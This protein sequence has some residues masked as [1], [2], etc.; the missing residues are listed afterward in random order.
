MK[1]ISTAA[2]A[3]L[4]G[5]LALT[6]G[7]AVGIH[8]P[9]ATTS[10][11][12]SSSAALKSISGASVL[13]HIKT[14][15]SD[16]FEGRSPGTRGEAMTTDY[17]AKQ[18]TQMGLAPG[19]PDGTYF[20]SVP[21][22][23]TLS[24]PALSYTVAGK[25]V[26]LKP[27]D[28]FVAWSPRQEAT[29]S[30]KQ[31][32][33]VFVG[34]GVVAP[35]YG[36][37]D[38]KGMDLRGKTIVML[39]NDPAIPDSKDPARLDPNMFQ[40]NAMTYYGRWTY[41]YEMAARLGAA[42]AIIVHET[43]PASYPYEVVRNS[44]G[45]ENF[46]VKM[47]GVH[48]DF[49]AVPAW[50]QLDRAR[51][52]FRASGLDFEAMK[53][54]ALSK[55]FK[56]VKLGAV[57]NFEVKNTWQDVASK[58]VIAKIEGSDPV[59]KNEYIVYTAHWDHFGIDETLPGPRT[60]QIYHGAVDNASGVAVLLE[61]AKAF[62]AMPVAPKRTVIFLA[63]TAEERGL[64]GAQYYAQHPL[65]PLQRT[66]ININMDGINTWGRTRDVAIVGYGKSSADDIV[67][68]I[69]ATQGRGVVSAPRP[70]SG[71]FY[72]SDQFEFAKVGVPVVYAKSSDSYIGK[73]ANY[74]AEKADDYTAHSYHKV[75]DIVRDDWDLSG[76]VE[77]VQMLFL[78]GLDVA[79]GSA[80][81]QWK[82]GAEFK[83]KRDQM[84]GNGAR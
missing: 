84:M 12:A 5:A 16:D 82:A 25:T 34:Y 33:M 70:E 24:K 39:I 53:R 7:C 26:T 61:L 57:A 27:S 29:V 73:P 22:V 80:Y 13:Q 52:L 3:A 55:D 58:N 31:S 20:Q 17:I 47:D 4:A 56:P 62:K 78:V 68:R 14:L 15:S 46:T 44:W 48:P 36:W 74:A 50:M 83:A 18:F 42:A 6:Y 51:E 81:P 23:G 9:A 59:L 43:K 2:L 19:N 75:T 65:Y 8:T 60:Q 77:D 71:G 32:E 21:L 49:P 38:Y 28:D 64:L 66:L 35:E 69:A 40:G 37:D 79:Q 63:V 10:T 30:I 54:A 1:Q 76:A 11:D 45:R 67:T 41:K 72:R